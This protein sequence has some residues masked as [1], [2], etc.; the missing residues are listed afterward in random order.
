MSDVELFT[1]H[2]GLSAA[3]IAATTLV[4]GIAVA[5]AGVFVR[6]TARRVWGPVRFM[7]DSLALVALTLWLVFAHALE[8]GA[9]A[10][11]YLRLGLFANVERAY[12]FSASCFTTLG[13]GDV[14][15]PE[16]FGL[17]AGA[18][19][20]NGF[21]LFGLSAAFLVEAASRLNLAAEPAR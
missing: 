17:L 13:F 1:H 10:A 15:L 4:H 2:A 9:W 16:G 19:A 8:I 3:M 6:V 5:A 7:R 14:L 21:I 20:A 12:Y 18:N 11:L